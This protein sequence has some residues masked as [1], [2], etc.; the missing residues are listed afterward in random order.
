M[1]NRLIAAAIVLAWTTSA[2]ADLTIKNVTLYDGTGAPARTGV[3]VV[4]KGDRIA[5]VTTGPAKSRG[6]VIDGTGKYLIPGLMD[7]HIHLPGGQTGNVNNPAERKL[8]IDKPTGMKYLHGYLYVGVTAV[9]DSSNNPDYIFAMRED[10]QKGLIVSPRIFGAGGIITVPNG[11]ASGPAALKVENWEQAQAELDRRLVAKP[12]MLKIAMDR[13]GILAQPAVPGLSNDMFTQI[14]Q[15]AASKG[16]RSTV[17]IAAEADAEAVINAGVAALAHPV[18]RSIANDSFVKLAAAKKIPIA[19]T[20][21]YLGNIARVQDDPG[22][23]D[24]PLYR[25]TIDP[26]EVERGKTTERQRYQD[27]GMSPMMKLML[28][29]AMRNTKR[30]HD[31]GAILALGTDRTQPPAVHQEL[32]FL[33]KAGISPFDC[34]RIAT[35]NAAVYV[36]RDKDFGSVETGKW[37]DMVLLD[38]DPAA[39]VKN[40]RAI[41]AVI[42]GG[43]D[44]DRSKLDIPINRKK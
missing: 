14:V 27:N 21:S 40:F 4:V 43:K 5:E 35:L 8:V 39:D 1:S 26:D 9:Y 15:Y 2:H 42:K 7:A 23:W 10:E 41:A 33:V 13:Q 34:I 28:P 31:A 36:G 38:A 17:H 18:W 12:D 29:H 24:D 11:Y 22:F 44:I 3:T 16:V 32:E 6:K 25:A 37:A 19:T 30:L 20:L